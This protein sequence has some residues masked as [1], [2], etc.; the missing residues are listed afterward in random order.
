MATKFKTK[1][2]KVKHLNE[3]FTDMFS[4][5]QAVDNFIYLTSKNRSQRTTEQHIRKCHRDR[6]LGNLLMRLDPV[7]FQCAD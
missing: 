7:A 6:T 1:Q 2:Q 3:L 5:E 4:E